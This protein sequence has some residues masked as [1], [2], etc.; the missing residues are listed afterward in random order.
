MKPATLKIIPLRDI[1]GPALTK[2][3]SLVE[4]IEN[5]AHQGYT[6]LSVQFVKDFDNAQGSMSL[7]LTGI[8][9]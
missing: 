4:E 1:E 9:Q 5:L 6:K 2:L 8:K 7:K 3:K